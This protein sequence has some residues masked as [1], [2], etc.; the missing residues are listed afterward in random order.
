MGPQ[1]ILQGPL[2]MFRQE[3]M[4]SSHVQ[5]LDISEKYHLF[6]QELNDP[7]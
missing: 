5:E 6:A 1:Q 2:A 3:T 4:G 7:S